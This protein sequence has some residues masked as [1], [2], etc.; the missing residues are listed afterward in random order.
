VSRIYPDVY[1]PKVVGMMWSMLA[2]EQVNIFDITVMTI[3]TW[4][5]YVNYCRLVLKNLFHLLV[6]FV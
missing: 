3:V 5:C 2:Q 6:F 1:K 4:L